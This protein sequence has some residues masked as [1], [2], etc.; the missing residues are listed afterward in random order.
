MKRLVLIPILIILLAAKGVAIELLPPSLKFADVYF[1]PHWL[2]LFLLVLTMFLDSEDTFTA[3]HFGVIFGLMMDILYTGI[4]GIYMFMIPFALYIAKLLF[5]LL[6]NNLLM[7]LL[8]TAI[9]VIIVELGLYFI[10]QFL[11]FVHTTF[12]FFLGERL[13]PTVLAN[14]VFM[15][16][17]YLPVKKLALWINQES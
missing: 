13:L 10:Y 2:L 17:I 5:R 4:L 3:I 6:Q 15:L 7:C 9:S 1:I 8:V 12:L 16:L 14:L 11:G